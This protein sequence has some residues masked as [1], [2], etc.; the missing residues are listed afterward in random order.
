MQPIGSP[1]IVYVNPEM[2]KVSVSGTALHFAPVDK[3][4]IVSVQNCNSE[5]DLSVIMTGKLF[6][7]RLYE[8]N[9]SNFEH[10]IGPNGQPITHNFTKSDAD[11]GTINIEFLPTVPGIV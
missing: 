5:K 8:L 9:E 3:P 1:F 6:A 7:Q 11:N 2:S 4:A 10:F